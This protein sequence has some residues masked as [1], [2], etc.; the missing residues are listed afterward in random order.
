MTMKFNSDMSSL[1]M[2]KLDLIDGLK[3]WKVWTN[4]AWS[5]INA[6]YG[7]TVI[8]VAWNVVSFTLFCLAIIFI[9]GALSKSDENDFGPHVVI[10]FLIFSYISSLINS[11]CMVFTSNGSWLK[12]MRLPYGLFIYKGILQN[13][14]IFIFNLLTAFIILLVFFDLK[15]S[16]TQWLLIP[17]FL[18][19]LLNSIAIYMLFGT[20]SVRY[21][22]FIHLIQ[23]I[24]RFSFF[25]T[26]I[27]WKAE[28][29]GVRGFVAKY[30]PLTHFIDIVRIPILYGEPALQSWT[31]VLVITVVIC[32]LALVVFVKYRKQ[33]IYWL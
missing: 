9:F 7:R 10:G 33:I 31:V 16:M 11:A 5:A 21:R 14:I 18:I 27:M 8:G 23:T 32:I 30:N 19:I 1:A 3:R 22:D 26:P 24:M 4:L 2:T 12:G 17:S 13:T 6:R 28:D 15:V 25:V 20:L 29:I